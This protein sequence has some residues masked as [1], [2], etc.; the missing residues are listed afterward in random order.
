MIEKITRRNALKMGTTAA[1]SAAIAPHVPATTHPDSLRPDDSLTGTAADA[2]P[3]A[4]ADSE[5]C[6]LSARQMA[7]FIRQKKLSAR[8]VMEAHLKQIQRVNPSCC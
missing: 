6:F 5:I 1:F 3:A 2:A 7:D 4:T 8:E